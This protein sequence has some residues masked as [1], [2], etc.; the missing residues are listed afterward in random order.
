MGA[1]TDEP[2]GADSASPPGASPPPGGRPAPG[3][4]LAPGGT[5]L[6]GTSPLTGGARTPDPHPPAGLTTAEAQR[7][8]G[9]HGRN[10]VQDTAPHPVR[11]ALSKVW[12]PV[13]WML[14]AAIVLELVLGQYAE[15]AVIAS[16]LLFNATLG[17]VQER[18]ARTTLD[19]LTTRLAPTASVR[20]DGEWSTIPAAGLVPG[21]LVTLSLG[22]VVPADVT[23]TD[24]S[25]LLDSSALTGESVPEE[26]GVGATAFAGALVKRGE[27]HATVTATGTGT[28]FGRGA[29]LVRSAHV[30]S[31]EQKAVFRIVR[32]IAFFNGGITVLIVVFSLLL[33]MEVGDLLSLVLVAVLASVPV[34]LPSMF[35]LAATVGAQELGHQ[36]VLPTRLSSLD[37]AAGVDV[38][39]V[40]KTGTLTENSLAVAEV[41]TAPSTDTPHVLALAAQASSQGGADPVDAA[42]R[43]AGGSTRSPTP[44]S[45]STS[46]PS[47]RSAS[48]PPR[49][50]AT[51]TAPPAPSGRAPTP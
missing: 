18:N 11:S 19:T 33:R 49:P 42:V 12:A 13:P 32:N 44:H 28:R 8:L 47:T 25:V 2:E 9:E 7:R 46:P 6:R 24:G 30:E 48:S 45:S 15:A 23:L 21:D 50:S 51:P 39:C 1:M 14:E 3:N 35:T 20:R 31:T 26:A 38:L 36:G 5:P 41:R 37:E 22:A 16:L 27:A 4:P 40:D 29:D 10:T 43:K 34:A 17:F